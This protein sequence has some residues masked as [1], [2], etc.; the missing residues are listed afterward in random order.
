MTMPSMVSMK[1]R[2]AGA[3]AVNRQP[4]HLAEHHGGPRTGQGAVKGGRLGGV[5]V[6]MGL[7]I[8]RLPVSQR[9]TV[10]C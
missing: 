4:D 3:E 6:A 9:C 7:T 8:R 5:T 2:L 10:S 1:P